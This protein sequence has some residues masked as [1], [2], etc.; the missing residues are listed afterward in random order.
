MTAGKTGYGAAAN[1]VSQSTPDR[2]SLG[3]SDLPGEPKNLK[4]PSVA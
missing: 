1:A 3:P 2:F 4:M